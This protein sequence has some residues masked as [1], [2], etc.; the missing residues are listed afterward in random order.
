VSEFYDKNSGLDE[1]RAAEALR[2][3]ARAV[4]HGDYELALKLALQV[5]SSI[6]DR[7]LDV[8]EGS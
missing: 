4:E 6:A 7:Q 5:A 2:T 1:S 8:A 3:A